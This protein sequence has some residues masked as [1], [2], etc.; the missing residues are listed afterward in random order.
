LALTPTGNSQKLSNLKQQLNLPSMWGVSEHAEY[1]E[2]P[3]KWHFC[4]RLLIFGLKPVLPSIF[5]GDM[6]GQK[7]R[8]KINELPELYLQHFILFVTFEW[9]QYVR[10]FV[11]GKHF[12]LSVM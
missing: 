2:G 6:K 11:S 3:W 12:Q 9:I 1:E 8:H 7:F 5:S 4:L 10:V